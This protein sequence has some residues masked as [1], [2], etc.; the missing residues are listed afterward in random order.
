MT[1]REGSSSARTSSTA[2][3]RSVDTILA[4]VPTQAVNA[5]LFRSP[6]RSRTPIQLK[7]ARK[8][9]LENELQISPTQ[10]TGPLSGDSTTSSNSNAAAAASFA[11]PPP[12]SLPREHRLS[13]DFGNYRRELSVLDTSAGS[14]IPLIQHNPPSA[15][16]PRQYSAPW[17]S[18]SSQ[19]G[20][21]MPTS[22][23]GTSFHDDS[24]DNH[25][26]NSQLS[27]GMRPGTSRTF[28]EPE[29]ETVAPDDERR[30]SLASVAT[31]GSNG[32]RGSVVRTGIHKKLQGFFGEEYAG[33]DGS[34]ASLPTQQQQPGKEQRTNSYSRHRDRKPSSAAEAR[35]SSPV[36]SRPRT[37]VPSSDVVPFLYQDSVDISRYGEAPVRTNLSGVDRERYIAEE[38]PQPP[39]KPST[40]RAQASAKVHRVVHGHRHNK[41]DEAKVA[42]PS[43]AREDMT[44]SG[45]ERQNTG[46]GSGSTRLQPQPQKRAPSPTPSYMSQNTLGQSSTGST[47]TMPGQTKKPGILARF[48]RPKDK[49]EPGSGGILKHL[50]GSVRSFAAQGGEG[51]AQPQPPYEQPS[52][53]TYGRGDGSLGYAPNQ[54]PLL[55]STGNGSGAPSGS[56]PSSSRH[57]AR[58]AAFGKLPFTKK[59]KRNRIQE[60]REQAAAQRDRN[61]PEMNPNLYNF[62]SD[63]TNMEGILQKPP[64]HEPLE[65]AVQGRD[66]EDVKMPDAGAGL[67]GWN[68]PDSWAVKKVS[69]LTGPEADETA[70]PRKFEKSQHPYCIRIFKADGT[71]ATLSVDLFATVADVITQFGRKT[72]ITDSLDN[73]QIIMKKHDLQRILSAGERPVI[74]QKRLL[75]QAGY[76]EKDDIEDLGREDQTYLCRFLFIPQRDSGYAAISQD[77]G[78]NKAQKFSHVD[79]SGRNL[80]TIPI[81]LYSKATEIISLNLSRNLSLGLPKDFIQSCINLRDI[82]YVNNE[83]HKL[84]QSL[85]RA[86]R[87]T[88]LD[89]SNNRLE[90]L[91]HAELD[92]LGGLI[93]LKLANNRLTHLPPYFAI[94]KQLR[95][96]NVSS[97]FLESFPEFLCD[98]PGLVDLDMSFNAVDKLPNAIGRLSNLERFVI[99]NNR[100]SGSLPHTFSQLCDLKEVDV[101]YNALSSIDV[102]AALPMVEQISADHN[103][104]S[105]FEGSFDKIRILRLNSNPVTRFEIK[106]PVPTLTTLVLSNAKLAHIADGS[107]ERMPNLVKLVLDKNH[108]VSLPRH[109]GKLR[110]L[111][112]FSI[113]RNALS[114]LPPEIGCLTELRI[115][116]VS[117]NN[118][119]KL[120]QEIWWASKLESLNI[121]ANVLA[122]F[123]KPSSRPPQIPTDAPSASD[124]QGSFSQSSMQTASRHASRE[125]LVGP[126]VGPLEGFGQRRPSQT[127]GG[128]LAVGSSPAQSPGGGIRSDSII[129]IYGK[130][131]RQAAVVSRTGS[132]STQ[133]TT[134]ATQATSTRKESSLLAK[135][136]NTFAVTLKNLYLADNQLDDDVF[137]ELTLLG[138]LRV[139]NLSYNDLSDL[140]RRTLRSWPQLVELYLSGN[141]LTSLPS[142]DFEDYSLLQVLHI[143]GNKFQTLPAE[144]GKAHRLTVLDVGS[145]SL[146]YNVSNWP[147]DWNWNCNPNLKYL[148]L[149]GNK[150]LEIKPNISYGNRGGGN[151]DHDRDEM[152]STDFSALVNLRILG[153]MDVTLT[154]PTIPDETEDRRVRTSGTLAGSMAYGMADTLGRNEHLSI[155]DLVVPRFN[156]NESETL[157]GMFDGQ[158]TTS[159]GSK[160]AKYLHEN[161]VR[162]FSDEVKMLNPAIHDTPVDALRRAFLSL[163]KELASGATQ[164]VEDRSLLSHRGSS[165]PAVLTQADLNSGGV[166]TVM[167]LEQME[168]Y[169]ANVGD[170][171]A[172][173]IQSDGSH[174]ILTRKHDPAEPGERQRIRDAGGWVS[175]Q[176]K[177]NDIIGVSRAF[178]YVQLLPAVQAA[179][180]ITQITLKE[181]DEMVI[182]ASSELWEYLSPELVVDVARSERN[183][184]VRAAQR[185]RD[186]AMAFGATGKIMVMMMG[187]SDQKRR[188]RIRMNR[189]PSM[190]LGPTSVLDD[191]YLPNKRIKRTKE[192]VEDSMLRRLEAEVQAPVGEISV[193][194]TDIKGSTAL[195]EN[196]QSAMRSAIRLH[197]EVMRRQLRII[198]GYEVKTEGD[199]FMVSFPTATSALLWCFSVQAQLLEIQWP[200]EILNHS[201]GKEIVD[202]DGNLIFRG[203]SVRMGVHFGTPVCEH[204]PVTRRMDYFGPMVNKTSRISSTADGGQIA[205]SA[206]FI[207]EIQRCLENYSET[208]RAGPGGGGAGGGIVDEDAEDPAAE[209]IRRELR[210]LSSQGF[211]VKPMGERKLKGLENPEYIYLMYPH[212]LAGR[213]THQPLLGCDLAEAA[214]TKLK[215]EAGRGGEG[216][217][218]LTFEPKGDLSIDPESIWALWRSSLRLEMICD[219]FE[220]GVSKPLYGPQTELVEKLATRGSDMTDELLVGFMRNLVLRIEACIANVSL[221]RGVAAATNHV[222]ANA[223]TDFKKY[224][225]PLDE[226]LNA[227]AEQRE[228]LERYRERFGEL[229]EVGGVVRGEVE[230]VE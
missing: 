125:E 26:T 100:L 65:S 111:E 210:S 12:S 229:G 4:P 35:D 105:V 9:K 57:G 202:A 128:L 81:V 3:S 227:M 180:H 44:Y 124:R 5:S 83:A 122:H 68:A 230:E 60:E 77:L 159:G 113:A 172:M 80:I 99:T 47:I 61:R 143:N 182:I 66:Q 45:R 144:L 72:H 73:Y 134:T 131:G 191:V 190:T 217:L 59:A 43:T 170:A 71:F 78:L 160:V 94:F 203:L 126:L 129:S 15:V 67:L 39:P 90:E 176:G 179:P 13:N 23:F 161:F 138:E 206:D 19:N 142:D 199:A 116:D 49:E 91:E 114:S 110:N 136:A 146:K 70:M 22:A 21:T 32:S 104:V 228:L 141:D 224:I 27:P 93:S 120:P 20:A 211:E 164:Y 75:E 185:L 219:G 145:N 221:R 95:T 183:D 25:S 115:F 174:R 63:L 212:T 10:L 51:Q 158:A 88:I 209:N 137:D 117:Q 166:A 56:R 76:E 1:R 37:P 208:E 40:A 17:M 6:S 62:D 85:G 147:Y 181:Q 149:S 89:V 96:L 177:L 28:S 123:P 31:S 200:S 204:D 53:D 132:L 135:L 127:L 55:P 58:Q 218:Q 48:R 207:S 148:N 79:L 153:L 154:I 121:S 54:E 101:R 30:P 157:L 169:V 69:D 205:V 34:D 16:S 130:G 165:P 33:R 186:L 41:S 214:A 42:R 52:M 222:A 162:I 8:E 188:D 7:I 156:S 223:V 38:P 86:S 11:A 197:N 108:F 92:R 29:A 106:S 102:I 74:I 193:V 168:L 112:H 196:N 151:R 163:N 140:P 167:F 155:I 220:D 175:R 87:L 36:P 46:M 215:E 178:G 64:S 189:G 216:D 173:L 187:V 213:I 195:W 14:R 133:E 18:P 192:A 2:S 171:Q 84:P 150:R 24:S 184:L 152:S 50:P 139:L 225:R 198:G 103:S 82:K 194:F 98:L 107:F 201:I 109:I 97:N 226:V 119:K 118:L